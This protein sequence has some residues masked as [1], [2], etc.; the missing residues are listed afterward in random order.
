MYYIGNVCSSEFIE[1]IENDNNPQDYVPY[2]RDNN[3]H[4]DQNDNNNNRVV[5]IEHTLILPSTN[6][7][8]REVLVNLFPH[9]FNRNPLSHINEFQSIIQHMMN[10]TFDDEH[11]PISKD[12]LDRL[13]RTKIDSIHVDLLSRD[14]TVCQDRFILMDE[15]IQLPCNHYFHSQCII[16][17]LNKV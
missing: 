5:T 12:V 11:I 16:P 10:D 1:K 13:V 4:I 14:C 2:I 3:D 7:F 8:V 15:C 6:T 17:W 9:E